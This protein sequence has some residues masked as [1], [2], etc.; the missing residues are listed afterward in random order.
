MEICKNIPFTFL[1]KVKY[2]KNHMQKTH[3]PQLL[4]EEEC[5]DEYI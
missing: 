1:K 5:I 2:H 4:E 3:K